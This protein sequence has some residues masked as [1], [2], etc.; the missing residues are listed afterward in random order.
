MKPIKIDHEEVGLSRLIDKFKDKPKVLG[1]FKSYLRRLNNVED[2]FFDLLEKRSIYNAEGAQLDILGS[3]FNVD[4][5]GRE[6]ESYRSAI[7]LKVF[8]K[9]DDGTTEVFMESLRIAANTNNVDFWEHESG[10]VHAL[11]GNGFNSKMYSQLQNTVPAGVNLV[12]YLD[13]EGDSLKLS[14]I[15]Y[16]AGDLQVDTDG[17]GTVADLQVDIDGL[18]T[19]ADLQVQSAA[20]SETDLTYLPELEDPAGVHLLAEI[21]DRDYYTLTG[22]LIFDDGS[23]MV[24][25]SGNAL[26]WESY[27]F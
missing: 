25:Q 17:L 13:D 11:V 21:M 4:R 20:I 7:L 9:K 24:D 18:G 2:V 12:L 16:L 6:D 27:T 8:Q 15:A 14:E 1:L 5:L 22:N 10:D 19:T 23:F 26:L 3:L